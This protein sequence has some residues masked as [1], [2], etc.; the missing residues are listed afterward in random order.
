LKDHHNARS[1]GS[2]S[3]HA[4][5][6]NLQ[7]DRQPQVAFRLAWRAEVTTTAGLELPAKGPWKPLS[8]TWTCQHGKLL[9]PQMRRPVAGFKSILLCGIRLRAGRRGSFIL[10]FSGAKSV[11]KR[12][13]RSTRQETAV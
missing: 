9:H 4:A 13:A 11:Q 3:E 7:P 1:N 8:A 12:G 6:D 10:A 2:R 5:F